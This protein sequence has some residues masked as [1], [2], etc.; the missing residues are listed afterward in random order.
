MSRRDK[1]LP[2]GIEHG[3]IDVDVNVDAMKTEL[4]CV[5]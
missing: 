1:V 4:G 2:C 3:C 5:D